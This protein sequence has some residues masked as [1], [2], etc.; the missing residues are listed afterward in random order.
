DLGIQIW[1]FHREDMSTPIC[2]LSG[3]RR[4]IFCLDF[5]ASN[6][7]LLSGG[8]DD[9]VIRHDVSSLSIDDAHSVITD[10][11]QVLDPHRDSIRGISGHPMNDELFLTASDDGRIL[12]HDGREP[13]PSRLSF[14]AQDIIQLE[15]GATDVRFHPHMEYIF[16][17]SED[18]GDL[19]LRDMRMAFGP[20]VN[21][22]QHGVVRR[23][24]TKISRRRDRAS[25]YA[26]LEVNSIAFDRQGMRL[27][28]TVTV[29]RFFPPDLVSR[30]NARQGFYPVIYPMNDDFPLAIL[31]GTMLPDG[32]PPP[33]EEG[34][35]AN[36]CTMKSSSFG[37]PGLDEDIYFVAGSDDFRG[38]VYR[39]PESADLI[40]A[41][42]HFSREE[43]EAQAESAT[44]GESLISPFFDPSRTHFVAPV[45]ITTPF[46]RLTGHKSIVN[47]AL[48]H[49]TLP[50][51]LTSGI[52]N[53]IVIHS[54][55]ED[56]ACVP[57]LRLSPT[58]V[59]R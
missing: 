19:C 33:P 57:Q 45:D 51:I 28:A 27:A 8:A 9:L 34:R 12:R 29:C 26:R 52:E 20:A 46:Y 43:W 18:R 17:T 41:C 56:A 11:M 44:V 40:E 2:H 36:A 49:P 24:N 23:Y 13:A 39:L 54:P 1:D 14:R 15:K 48:F 58:T 31:T 47:T 22:T 3:H 50:H 7:Y 4:N 53:D 5:S 42:Q 10:P 25:S 32:T 35:Y 38:Y 30:L 6:R 37:G 16:A 55:F 59:R 21:R